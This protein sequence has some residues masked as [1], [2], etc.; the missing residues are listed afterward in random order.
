MAKNL[1][2]KIKELEEK[3][4][5]LSD[6]LIDSI[7]VIDAEKLNYE[8]ITPS[9]ERISGY[10]VEDHMNLSIRDRLTP[11]S[12]RKVI[13]VL[14]EERKGFEQGVKAI[15][16]MELDLVRKDGSTYWV[17][18]RA[19]FY[20]EEGKPL[21]IVG[22]SRDISDQKKIEKQQADLIKELG[23]AIA[24]K[25]R[26]LEENKIL[27]GLLPICS[28]CKRIRDEENRWWPLEAYVRKKTDA[29]FT[30]TICPDCEEV[31]YGDI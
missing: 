29:E 1:K 15:R 4:R 28:G 31:F 30:H 26:L 10:S 27:R 8:Y 9:V 11:E 16:S 25:E 22:I 17:E 23:E 7:W 3:Y 5:Y 19:K 18:V 6:N 12:F 14:T 13:K 24:E 2:E 20:K 21:K